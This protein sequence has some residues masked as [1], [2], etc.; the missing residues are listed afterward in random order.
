[1]VRQS[2]A[3][4]GESFHRFI[5]NLN[6]K[7]LMSGFKFFFNLSFFLQCS[8]LDSIISEKTYLLKSYAK[9]ILEKWKRYQ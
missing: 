3:F 6:L 2:F 7:I 4:V 1:M 8:K 5:F 9:W